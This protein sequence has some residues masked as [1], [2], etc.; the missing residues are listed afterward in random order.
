MK[1]TIENYIRNKKNKYLRKKLDLNFNIGKENQL[2]FTMI[3]NQI[4]VLF[5]KK[6]TKTILK[7]N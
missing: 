2:I 3:K 1:I 5:M 6:L 7:T 4:L